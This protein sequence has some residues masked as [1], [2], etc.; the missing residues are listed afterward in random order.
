M[1]WNAHTQK[2]SNKIS[3]SL[4]IMNRLKQYLP[5]NIFRTIYSSLI[6]PHINYSILVWGF[7]SSRISKLQKRA[8]RMISCSKYN[9]HTKPLLQSLNLLKVV[10]ISK[11]KPLKFC[12]KYPRKHYHFILMKCSAKLLVDTIMELDNDRFKIFINIQLEPI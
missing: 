12:F 7:K 4:G 9:A 10:D 8:A 1:T 2:I 3:G 11:I 6:L 5:Q